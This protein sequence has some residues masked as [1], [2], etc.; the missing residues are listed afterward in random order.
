VQHVPLHSTVVVPTL[1]PPPSTLKR[2][3]SRPWIPALEDRF[4]PAVITV[5]SN[6]DTAEGQ[7][8]RNSIAAASDGDTI[9]FCFA[10]VG[11][12]T[13]LREG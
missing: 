1:L 4:A 9:D 5:F 7:T 8:L 6:A 11:T 3:K 13:C 10:P 12:G 2:R